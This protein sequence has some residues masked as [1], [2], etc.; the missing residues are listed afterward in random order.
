MR[1]LKSTSLERLEYGFDSVVGFLEPEPA[2]IAVEL[3][4]VLKLACV[5][6]TTLLSALP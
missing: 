4:L 6:P 5:G 1:W 2:E 3:V